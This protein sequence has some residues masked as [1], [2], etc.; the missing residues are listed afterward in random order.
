MS[1]A[2]KDLLMNVEVTIALIITLA[3][4]GLLVIMPVLLPFIVL[5]YLAGLGLLGAF[6][7]ARHLH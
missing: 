7:N 5:A 3:S 6:N 2:G 4:F 1:Q